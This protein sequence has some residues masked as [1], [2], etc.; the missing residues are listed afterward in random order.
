[1]V[2]LIVKRRDGFKCT[3]CGARG[4]LEVHH[5][6]SVRTRPEL[7]FDVSNL[8]CLCPSCHTKQTRIEL[9]QSPDVDPAR[10]AWRDLLRATTKEIKC[11]NQ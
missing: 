10:E 4:R 8:K 3:N 7:A 1:M 11:S 6:L 9:G 2:R 5:V